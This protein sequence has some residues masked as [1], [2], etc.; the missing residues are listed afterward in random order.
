[1]LRGVKFQFPSRDFLVR[2]HPRWIS[3]V[4]RRRRRLTSSLSRFLIE[5]KDDSVFS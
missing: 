5:A 2:C 3:W 1:V 4:L